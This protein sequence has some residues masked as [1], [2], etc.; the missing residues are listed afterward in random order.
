MANMGLLTGDQ[1][2]VRLSLG[3]AI[4]Q[5]VEVTE[6]SIRWVR[7][8]RDGDRYVVKTY[9][10]R[11]VEEMPHDLYE[12]PAVELDDGADQPVF[13]SYE[14]EEAPNVDEALRLA[15]SQGAGREGFHNEG[16]LAEQFEALLSG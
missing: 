5:V 7:V 9:R 11:R 15:E 12:L 8:L 13:S 16:F 4:E 14:V 6:E 1:A 3:K 2:I 10:A